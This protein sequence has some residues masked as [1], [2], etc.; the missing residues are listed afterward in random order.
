[1]S[2]QPVRYPHDALE[3]VIMGLLG[4]RREYDTVGNNNIGN[5]WLCVHLKVLEHPNDLGMMPVFLILFSPS[6]S[7]SIRI[8]TM[9]MSPGLQFVKRKR[10][11]VVNLR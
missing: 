1:M 5:I 4:V 11:G 9:G 2:Q 6:T 7:L 3:D 10:Q 8:C